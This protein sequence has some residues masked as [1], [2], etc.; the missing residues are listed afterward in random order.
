MDLDV[1]SGVHSIH[2]YREVSVNGLE[3]QL[4]KAKRR[5]VQ[6]QA[7]TLA[8]CTFFSFSFFSFFFIIGN[9]HS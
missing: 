4:S 6:I 3:L 8:Q 2:N 1:L 9:E 7:A 5:T